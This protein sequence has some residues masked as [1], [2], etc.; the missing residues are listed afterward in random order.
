LIVGVLGV[1]LNVS[2]GMLVGRQVT[3]QRP[4]DVLR[5]D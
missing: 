4:L 1:A 3:A 2:V 5:E